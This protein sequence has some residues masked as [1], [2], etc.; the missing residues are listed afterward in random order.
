MIAVPQALPHIAAFEKLGFGMFVHLGLY[1]QLGAG[2]WIQF[3]NKMSSDEYARLQLSFSACCFDAEKLVLLA[4]S[5]GM[6]YIV[7]TTRHHEGFSLYDTCGMNTYD[8]PH[9]PAKRDLVREFVEACRKY[10]IVPFFYHTT[11]DWHWHGKKTADLEVAEFNE[12]LD[13]LYDSVK[14]LCRNYGR[15]GGFWFDGNW[16]RPDS[17]W[18][19]ERLYSMIREHQPDAVIIDNIGIFQGGKIGIGVDAVTFE[20]QAAKPMN[21]EGQKKYVAAEVCKT[22]NS[23]WGIGK[24]DFNF[25]SPREIIEQLCHSRGCGANFL[26]NIGPEAQGAVPAYEKA[27]LELAGRWLEIYGEAFYETKTVSGVKCTGRDFI[28][29]NG[30]DFYYYVFGLGIQGNSDVTVDIDGIGS[31][32]IDGFQQ[33]ILSAFWMDNNEAVNF[34]QNLSKKMAAFQC[35]G[36]P[37]GTHT[38]VRVMKIK[39]K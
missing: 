31:R 28:L 33:K 26:L 23:H 16:A 10:G 12:Y 5:A 34:T 18:K 21:R 24:N 2:E 39:T 32:A 3:F 17:D 7:L 1:S 29:Q 37:Y 15:I 25:K 35:T 6:K 30:S 8:A 36:F 27:V 38:V 11:I 13:Y 4:K 19:L 22:M 14:L 9:A 20:N